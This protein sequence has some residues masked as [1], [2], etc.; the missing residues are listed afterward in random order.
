MALVLREGGVPGQFFITLKEP[1]DKERLLALASNLALDNWGSVLHVYA[2]DHRSFAVRMAEE[3]ARVVAEDERIETVEQD[4]P[5]LNL[6]AFPADG[7]FKRIWGALSFPAISWGLDRI[8]LRPGNGSYEPPND[9]QCVTVYVVDTGI[10]DPQQNVFGGRLS[11]GVSFFPPGKNDT[12]DC[13]NHGS[14]VASVIGGDRFGVARQVTLV[15]VRVACPGQGDAS[16][17]AKGVDWV[18]SNARLPAV[19]NISMVTQRCEKLEDAVRNAIASGITCVVAAGDGPVDVGR[20]SPARIP[21]AIT[22]AASTSSN[23]VWPQS[24]FGSLVDLFAPGE[25]VPAFSSSGSAGGKYCGTS[26]AA[27]FVSGAAAIYLAA[28][29]QAPPA[30]VQCHLVS[31]AQ[32]IIIGSGSSTDRFLNLAT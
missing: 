32:R 14:I 19:M 12:L 9:G 22:V 25:R 13:G 4:Q 11:G 2:F 17:V 21:E 7:F 18:N 31:A 6:E 1:L 10:S 20:V 27:G 26:I 8:D 28:N 16:S 30:E 23:F 3:R 5:V 24:N 15:P 29:P